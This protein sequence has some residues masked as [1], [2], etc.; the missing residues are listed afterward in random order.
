MKRLIMTSLLVMS[1][2]AFAHGNIFDNAFVSSLTSLKFLTLPTE[3]ISSSQSVQ[4]RKAAEL[5]QNDIQIY[6]FDGEMSLLLSEAIR[7]KKPELP[8]YSDDEIVNEIEI[9]TNAILQDKS[10]L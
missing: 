1:F 3:Q 6:R 2:N 7:F 4:I 9:L 5:L 8:D 10:L